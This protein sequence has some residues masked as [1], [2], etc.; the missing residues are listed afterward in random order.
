M[1]SEHSLRGIPVSPW[2]DVECVVAKDKGTE[3]GMGIHF[4]KSAAH[5]GQWILQTKLSNGGKIAEVLPESAPLST[6]RVI[7]AS[8]GGLRQG[9]SGPAAP[10]PGAPRQEDVQVQQYSKSSFCNLRQFL[11]NFYPGPFLRV[12]RWPSRGV[13]RP[14]LDPVRHGP[15]H[16]GDPQGN[17]QHALVPAGPQKDPHHPVALPQ[18]LHHKTPRFGSSDHR[19]VLDKVKTSVKLGHN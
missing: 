5:G 7:T 15:G 3:G 14:R 2:L 9:A 17:H 8:R 11:M 18:P 19:F 1:F 13:H 10:L 4:F 16:G 12:P 6:L